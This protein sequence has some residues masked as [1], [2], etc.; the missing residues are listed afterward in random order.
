V[1]LKVVLLRDVVKQVL[2]PDS[3]FLKSL[4]ERGTQNDVAG[5]I[6]AAKLLAPDYPE[7]PA[8]PTDDRIETQV[9]LALNERFS[10]SLVFK[11]A[12]A[13]LAIALT[14]FTFGLFNVWNNVQQAH[15]VVQKMNSELADAATL[16]TTKKEALDL[17]LSSQ[18]Q[19]L[20]AEI[21]EANEQARE[22][23]NHSMEAL[24]KNLAQ[25]VNEVEASKQS[26]LAK[27]DGLTGEVATERSAALQKVQ[28]LEQDAGVQMQGHLRQSYAALDLEQQ[29]RVDDLRAR[30]KKL[31]EDIKE[32]TIRHVLGELFWVLVTSAVFSLIA[33]LVA[34]LAWRTAVRTSP[35]RQQ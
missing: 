12:V 23:Q 3:L 10:G 8:P 33:L 30:A 11:G 13:A 4:E 25:R 2:P 15:A 22:A 32:P 19:K 5:L 34:V 18:K 20:V 7:G 21:N 24:N 35:A 14:L 1:D 16:M 27:M 26:A 29:Q 9:R 31:I 6:A 28:S 17:D